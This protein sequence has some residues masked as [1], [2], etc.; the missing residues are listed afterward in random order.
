[1]KQDM[2]QRLSK[3][4]MPEK[5]SDKMDLSDLDMPEEGSPEEEAQESPEEEKQE[6]AGQD[7][8]QASPKDLAMVSDEDLLAEIQKRGLMKELDKGHEGAD[9]EDVPAHDMNA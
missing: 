8:E 9:Y 6:D 1:M 2:K 7:Q 3:L 4:K 5:K